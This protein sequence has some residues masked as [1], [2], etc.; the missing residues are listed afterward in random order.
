M[1]GLMIATAC[2]G[3]PDPNTASKPTSGPTQTPSSTTTSVPTESSQAGGSASPTTTPNGQREFD[4][5]Q[6]VAVWMRHVIEGRTVAA[7]DA[8]TARYAAD[9]VSQ[10]QAEGFL[11]AGAGCEG[12]ARETGILLA[13]FNVPTD[14][15]A[16]T[17]VSKAPR[18]MNVRVRYSNGPSPVYTV[19]LRGNRWM[20]DADND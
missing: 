9:S 4:A 10:M 2:G 17:V 20:V 1:L 8:M 19:V 3:E 12:W 7:C 16:Y 14:V 11:D 13:T 6:A 18:K 15:D 5:R